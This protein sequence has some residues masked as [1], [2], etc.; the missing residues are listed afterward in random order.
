M[1]EYYNKNPQGKN[2][3]DCTVRAISK[4]TGTDW[5]KTYIDLCLQ[6]LADADMPSSNAVWGHYLSAI[7]YRRHLVPDSCPDCYT[8]SRF[9]DDHSVGTFILALSGHVV[10]VQ[11]GIIYDSWD[12]GNEIVLYYWCKERND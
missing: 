6:G 4:A 3:G 7:G 5:D 8:V 2:V 12:S 1:F 9:A 11:D 10:C